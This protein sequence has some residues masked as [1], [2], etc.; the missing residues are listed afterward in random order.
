MKARGALHQANKIELLYVQYFLSVLNT[1]KQTISAREVEHRNVSML[2]IHQ[3]SLQRENSEA[4]LFSVVQ[5]YMV[6]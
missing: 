2:A 6:Q 1:S 5:C 3:R 4:V